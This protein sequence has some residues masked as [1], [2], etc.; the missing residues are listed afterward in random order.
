MK[1]KDKINEKKKKE[2]HNKKG[3]RMNLMHTLTRRFCLHMLQEVNECLV[4]SSQNP[5][6]E[7]LSEDFELSDIK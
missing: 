6:S 2:F 3:K 5:S 7:S 1:G 4:D